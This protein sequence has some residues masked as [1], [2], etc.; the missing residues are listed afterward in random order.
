MNLSYLEYLSLTNCDYIFK[1]Q[2]YS[3]KEAI[4]V[5]LSYT[6]DEKKQ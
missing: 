2:N 5:V 1:N 6:A 4:K 3:S